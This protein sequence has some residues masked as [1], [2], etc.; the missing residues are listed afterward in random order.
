[1]FPISIYP[2]PQLSQVTFPSLLHGTTWTIS[3]ITPVLMTSRLVK[4]NLNDSFKFLAIFFPGLFKENLIPCWVALKLELWNLSQLLF[5]SL[6]K[7]CC[8][9][10]SCYNN[11]KIACGWS[12]GERRLPKNPFKVSVIMTQEGLW[13]VTTLIP[14]TESLYKM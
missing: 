8:A 11:T 2:C 13:Y 4:I 1:M 12:E 14:L 5:P 6:T 7:L 3:K 10:Q 9:H